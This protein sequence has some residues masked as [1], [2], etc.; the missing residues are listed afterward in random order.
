LM[1]DHLWAPELIEPIAAFPLA[2]G[3]AVLGVDFD[4][5][6]C[7]DLDDATKDSILGGN[8]LRLLSERGVT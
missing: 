5:P 6:R 7:F 3:E 4:I 2:D 8:T 1:S